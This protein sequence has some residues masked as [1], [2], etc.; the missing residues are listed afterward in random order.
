[1][2]RDLQS[3]YLEACIEAFETL[4]YFWLFLLLLHDLGVARV[5]MDLLDVRTNQR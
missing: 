5:V 2:M 3:V 1:M 4:K